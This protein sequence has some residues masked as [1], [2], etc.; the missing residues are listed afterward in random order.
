[1]E[2][3]E[4]L[5]GPAQTANN[6][7]YN[8]VGHRLRVLFFQ[9][10]VDSAEVEWLTCDW[11]RAS[12]KVDPTDKFGQQKLA[13]ERMDR[14]WAAWHVCLSAN[15]ALRQ[16]GYLQEV[17]YFMDAHVALATSKVPML[18]Y[19]DVV[20]RKLSP[21]QCEIQ[22]G[23]TAELTKV[24]KE[25]WMGAPSTLAISKLLSKGFPLPK[26]V[27]YIRPQLM[28]CGACA[29]S[30]TLAKELI[31]NW[32]LGRY[33]HRKIIA[34]PARRLVIMAMN[35]E[36]LCEEIHALP[37][38]SLY[39]VVA[40]C[41]AGV[42]AASTEIYIRAVGVVSRFSFFF[43]RVAAAAE[44]ALV[45]PNARL[46]QCVNVGE[47]QPIEA[48]KPVV[49]QQ[50]MCN[51]STTA[52]QR[53]SVKAHL[54]IDGFGKFYCPHCKVLH[55]K[56]GPQPRAA[57][58]RLGVS[59]DL[60]H[61]F[62][63]TA[64]CNACGGETRYL[65]LLGRVTK[66]R[67]GKRVETLTVC[68]FCGILTHDIH[69]HGQD[70]CCPQC[71]SAKGVTLVSDARPCPCGWDSR[72]FAGRATNGARCS[73]LTVLDDDGD[74]VLAQACP[75]HAELSK[76]ARMTMEQWRATVVNPLPRTINTVRPRGAQSWSLGGVL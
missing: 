27:R 6:S 44:A 35:F 70:L 47:V 67:V 39:Y 5:R 74:A 54:G 33:T 57:K 2:R 60:D 7:V 20:R 15:S 28:R 56:L 41:L 29:V 19:G 76:G 34:P 40:E 17:G 11:F 49:F 22:I 38:R 25:L 55:V 10:D 30:K 8:S 3:S 26:S 46:Q 9:N 51:T 24:V 66:A 48:A 64:L 14:I 31:T 23:I 68:S 50:W 1:V 12:A 16:A 61:P 58:S 62:S 13:R 4:F 42:T 71:A 69:M 72:R 75:I 65:E 63:T 45:K 18:T 53:A 52:N 37:S 43:N 73:Y 21:N 32:M 59:I 36:E